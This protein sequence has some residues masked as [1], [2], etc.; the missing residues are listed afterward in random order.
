MYQDS[1]EICI[2]IRG[3]LKKEASPDLIWKKRKKKVC[4]MPNQPYREEDR[5]N[6]DN[7]K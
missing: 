4:F 5:N 1:G 6:N 7:N 3:G 2:V